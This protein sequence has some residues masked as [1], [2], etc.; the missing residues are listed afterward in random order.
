MIYIGMDVSSKSFV[1]HGID[2]RK[3]VVCRE[4]IAPCKGSLL[5]LLERLGK[6][7]KLVVFEA[8]NQLKWIA[9][10]L[11]KVDGV[12][13]HVVHPNELKW[14]SQSSGKTDKVDARKMAELARGDL[15]PRKVHIVEG[16]VR[17]LREMLSGREVLQSKRVALV[18][19]IRAMM[20]QEGVSLPEKFFARLDWQ[21]RLE[22]ARVSETTRKIISAYMHGICGLQA[23]EDELTEQ[24]MAIKDDRLKQLESIPGIGS[25]SSRVLLG[26]LDNAER[27]ENKKSAAKYGALTPTVR[28]S[29]NV[30]HHGHICRDGRH[31]IRKVLL[32]CAHTVARMKRYEARPLKEFFERIQKR[33]GKKIAVVALARKL[34]TIAYGVLKA[35]TYFDPSRLSFR[36][37]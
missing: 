23:A 20:L 18:N 15:L 2:S 12:E 25:L 36:E 14:I 5:G 11:K 30:S 37:A 7:P 27:F 28:Q 32:Q 8:G 4:E 31:E 6:E 3:R 35:G 29:G 16:Q 19:G 13:I 21:E 10:A 17:Q 22:K 26:A 34:L 24:I 33:R 1:I 9:Q